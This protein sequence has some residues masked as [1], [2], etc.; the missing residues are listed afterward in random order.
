M[1]HIN[2]KELFI[3]RVKEAANALKV[4]AGI[5]VRNVKIIWGGGKLDDDR[6][7]QIDLSFLSQRWI[8]PTL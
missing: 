7:F 3:K 5:P 8:E 4:E 2:P 1:S 6:V